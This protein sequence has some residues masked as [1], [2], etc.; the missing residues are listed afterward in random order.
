MAGGASS[1]FTMPS[2][3]DLFNSPH[4]HSRSPSLPFSPSPSP[5]PSPVP[6]YPQLSLSMFT[7][8]TQFQGLSQRSSPLALFP[9]SSAGQPDD[10]ASLT[11]LHHPLKH[12]RTS[13]RDFGHGFSPSMWSTERQDRFDV[14]MARITASCGFPYTWVENPE[15]L[16]FMNE[17]I[18]TAQ[19]VRRQRLANKLI[20]AE[21]AKYRASAIEKCR[22][23]LVTLQ[24]DGWSGI[25]F[26]HFVAFMITTNKREVS[27]YNLCFHS[28][29]IFNTRFILFKFT[30]HH[31][32]GKQ[33]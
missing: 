30:I 4:L 13:S 8:G 12:Q 10:G 26:H 16:A 6:A 22:G 3:L 1:S 33:L 29:L 9:S 21:V 14:F 23:C 2:P 25:N 27:R 28:N 5:S 31:Q 7:G 20:P 11:S 32:R 15:V 19:P 17:F 18:P 24:C